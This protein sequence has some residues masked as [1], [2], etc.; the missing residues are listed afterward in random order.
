MGRMVTCVRILAIFHCHVMCLLY[1]SWLCFHD[2]FFSRSVTWNNM[3]I[4]FLLFNYQLVKVI[5]IP[6]S[7][8][9]VGFSNIADTSSHA[10]CWHQQSKATWRSPL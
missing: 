6:I 9:Y 1:M 5:K 7:S 4:R 10:R 2:L 3:S 8:T